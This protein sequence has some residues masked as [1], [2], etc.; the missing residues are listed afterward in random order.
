MSPFN[1]DPAGAVLG[2]PSLGRRWSIRSA[3]K[4]SSPASAALE[5]IAAR[6]ESA[7]AAHFAKA[8]VATK[9]LRASEGAF[10]EL[11]LGRLFE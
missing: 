9:S 3:V 8:P 5:S 7:T 4:K 1:C 11:E 6:G 2:P 10:G